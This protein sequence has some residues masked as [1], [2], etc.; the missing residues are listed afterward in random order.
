MRALA[1]LRA[2]GLLGIVQTGSTPEFRPLALSHIEGNLAAVYVLAYPHALEACAD[3]T[4]DSVD[5]DDTPTDLSEGKIPFHAHA[6]ES[7]HHEPLRGTDLDHATR[8][9]KSQPWRTGPLWSRHITPKRKDER[10]RAAWAVKMSLLGAKNLSDH[11]LASLLRPFHLAGWTISDILYALDHRPDGT[12][13]PHSGMQG[14][15]HT[16]GWMMYRLSPWIDEFGTVRISHTQQIAADHAL[17]LAQ[18]RAVREHNDKQRAARASVHRIREIRAA[19]ADAAP[20]TTKPATPQAESISKKRAT[21]EMI[22][23]I[24]ATVPQRKA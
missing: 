1:D 16:Q 8:E 23:R 18:Q 12:L 11:A 14:V 15:K 2:A 24:R 7:S 17:R 4:L 6:R 3:E 20:R 10:L 5:I 22:A 9:Q 21:A 19:A 13:W